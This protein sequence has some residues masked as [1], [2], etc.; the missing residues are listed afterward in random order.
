M[1]VDIAPGQPIARLGHGYRVDVAVE[2]WNADDV[3]MIP[4]TALFKQARAWSV[5]RIEN[6]RARLRTV[7][8]GQMNGEVAEIR[9]GLN[10]GDQLIEHPSNRVE[11]GV[12]VRPRKRAETAP[13]SSD[14][15]VG[16][17]QL[18]AHERTASACDFLTQ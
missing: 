7:E 3:L 12:R 18:A 16:A 9:A 15:A 8:V 13:A 14:E 6:S 5:Y 4:M 10:A 1:V 11:D 2:V 17:E